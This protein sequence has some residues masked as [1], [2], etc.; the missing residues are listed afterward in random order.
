MRRFTMILVAALLAAGMALAAPLKIGLVTDTG[1]LND[2]SFNHLAYVGLLKAKSELGVQIGVVQSRAQTDYVPNLTRFAQQG[3]NLV[4]AVGFL[5]KDATEQVSKEFPNTHFL[6]IDDVVNDRSNVTS[7][8]FRTQECGYLVGAL[9]GMVEKDA[10]L[11]LPGL[12]HNNIIGVIGGI[13]I[14][15]VNT[16]IAGY[17]QGAQATDPGV[18]VLLGYTG[19]FNDPASGKALAQAQHSRGADIIFQVAGGTGEGVI[20][21]AKE[22]G[23]YAIGVDADQAYL[24]PDHVLTSATKGVDTAVFLTVKRLKNATLKSGVEYFDLANNG[25]GIGSVLASIPSAMKQKIEQ[26]KQD[27][28][29]GKIKVSPSIPKSVAK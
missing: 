17:A 13:S 14:P 18:K 3:Y 8:I 21:A 11:N 9:A 24:A 5:M 19:N 27:I 22:G 10:S 1:G 23:Y 4:V 2:H 12:R 15:P 7:A 25:V 28:I 20:Q 6:L 16:Y 29:S 26:L